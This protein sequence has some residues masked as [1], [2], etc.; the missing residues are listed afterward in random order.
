MIDVLD[1]II[2][3]G[4]KRKLVH[5]YTS[6][7]LDA[8]P[9]EVA[10]DGDTYVNFGS[11]SYLGLEHDPDIKRGVITAVERYGTQFSSSRTYLSIGLY[12]ELEGQ[13]RRIYNRPAIV[14]ASTTLGHLATI[15]V[16]VGP[17][18]AVVLDFRCIPVCK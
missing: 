9:S 11:C 10:I 6:T 3:D 17:N 1:Q 18:D 7:E 5:N 12:S 15:P 2:E 8:L 14:T 16:V 13:M 4:F